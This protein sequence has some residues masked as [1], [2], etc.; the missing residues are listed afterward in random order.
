MGDMVFNATFNNISAISWRSIL[1]VE[2]TGVPIESHR[3]VTSHWQISSH[4]VVSSTPAWAG[5]ELTILVVIG[6]DCTGSCKSNYHTITARYNRKN[7]NKKGIDPKSRTS[8]FNCVREKSKYSLS[9]QMRAFLKS[10]FKVH[11]FHS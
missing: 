4:N 3:P 5:F 8:S 11:T 1:S 10:K 9:H 7:P 6:T 2:E